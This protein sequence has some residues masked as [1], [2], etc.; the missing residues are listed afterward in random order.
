MTKTILGAFAASVILMSGCASI[1]SSEEQSINITTSNNKPAEV[2]V[3]DKTVTAPGMVVVLRDGKDKVVKTNAEGCDNATPI[4]KT[5]T[6]V[7][8][9]NIIIGGVLGSTTDGATG[10]M[11]DY[12][13]SVEISC[14]E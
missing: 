5:I 1:T 2:T 3:D 4:K 9:G 6:P 14:P 12:E 11:W 7:F 8:W 13:E 10:K